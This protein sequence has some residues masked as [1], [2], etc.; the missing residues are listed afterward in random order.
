[1]SGSILEDCDLRNTL[2]G[3]S[4]LMGT[5]FINCDLT[6]VDLADSWRNQFTRFEGCRVEGLKMEGH[7]RMFGCDVP[8]GPEAEE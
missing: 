6:H 2:W 8:V 1:M 4:N 5:T 3:R 7:T